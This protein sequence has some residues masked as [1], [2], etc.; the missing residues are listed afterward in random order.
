ML[1][2][3]DAI[4]IESYVDN[5]SFYSVEKKTMWPRSVSTKLLLPASILKNPGSQKL[6]DVTIDRKLHFNF[7]YVP[8][9]E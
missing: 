5:N 7:I 2:M 4:D 6:L 8:T 1:F 3:V 9:S